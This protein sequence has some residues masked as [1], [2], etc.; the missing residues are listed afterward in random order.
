M[1]RGPFKKLVIGS[2]VAGFAVTAVHAATSLQ[3]AVSANVKTQDHAT[4]LLTLLDTSAPAPEGFEPMV[5]WALSDPAAVDDIVQHLGETD[6]YLQLW[7]LEA[8]CRLYYFQ[9]DA[10]T[11][12]LGGE[13]A[14]QIRQAPDP[15]LRAAAVMV[16]GCNPNED[17]AVTKLVQRLQEDEAT[18]IAAALE[19]VR[20][21]VTTSQTTITRRVEALDD[22]SLKL[23]GQFASA[24]LNTD[25][26]ALTR[27]LPPGL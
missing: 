1:M 15:R 17:Q 22:S 16:E 24:N 11:N 13:I 27:H 19:L 8:A 7:A 23:L 14:S 5:P 3:S 25:Y 2:Y 12:T 4:E 26:D 6:F 21:G 20:L 10:Q 9:N 18:A